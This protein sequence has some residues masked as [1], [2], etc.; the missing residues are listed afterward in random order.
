MILVALSESV[1]C[2]GSLCGRKRHLD[3]VKNFPVTVPTDRH[4]TYGPPLD[5]RPCA[6]LSGDYPGVYI[7]RSPSTPLVP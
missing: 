4:E 1:G 2:I 3:R 7:R 5:L 6:S